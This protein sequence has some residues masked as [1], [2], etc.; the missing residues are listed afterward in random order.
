MAKNTKATDKT[1]INKCS[2]YKALG[3]TSI[4]G[5]MNLKLAN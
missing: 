4:P 5:A 1:G 3:H 2:K